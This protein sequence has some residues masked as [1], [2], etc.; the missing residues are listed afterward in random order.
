MPPPHP[1]PGVTLARALDD[2]E[3]LARLLARVRESRARLAALAPTLPQALQVR[4]GPLDEAGWTLLVA[5]PAAA[6]KLRQSL[7]TL[8]RALADA[9]YAPV[10]LRIKVQPP[11][12]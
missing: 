2:S 4:A 10:P 7:P 8:A 12:R 6:A 5:H 11:A 3:P 9:G 1:A